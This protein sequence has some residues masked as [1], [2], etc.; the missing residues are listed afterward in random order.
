MGVDLIVV[1]PVDQVGEPVALGI[2]VGCVDLEDVACEDNLR[3]LTGTRDDRFDL[4]RGQILRFIYN[5]NHVAETSSA[6]VGE[7][8]N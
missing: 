1:Q 7:R 5:E 3:I 6:N 4:V 2:Q 8:H